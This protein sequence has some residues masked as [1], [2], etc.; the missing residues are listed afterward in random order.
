MVPILNQLGHFFDSTQQYSQYTQ[1]GLISQ[2]TCTFININF[3]NQVPREYA[4]ACM[5]FM[6]WGFK[7]QSNKKNWLHKMKLLP[8]ISLSVFYTIF[9]CYWG[10]GEGGGARFF[11]EHPA[12]VPEV[13]YV[14]I[15]FYPLLAESYYIYKLIR[16]M[17]NT[18]QIIRKPI[19]LQYTCTCTYRYSENYY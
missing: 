8:S 13:A 18:E 17:N 7:F 16:T 4:R 9:F 10:V 6:F 3:S 2:Y 19:L 5:H 15:H 14:H 1:N 12:P 11:L